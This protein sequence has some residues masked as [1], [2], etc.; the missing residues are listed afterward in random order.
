MLLVLVAAAIVVTMVCLI[1]PKYSQYRDLQQQR[2]DRQEEKRR[3]ELRLRSLQVNQE[4]FASDPA[5][6]ERTAR[7]VGMVKTNETVCKVGQETQPPAPPAP[8]PRVNR[9]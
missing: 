4:R 6:V 3:E 7:S 8:K 9:R 1:I 5:F 2:T